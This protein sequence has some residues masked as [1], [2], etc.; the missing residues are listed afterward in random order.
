MESGDR[1]SSCQI[2]KLTFGTM[3]GS[4][5][6]A[7]VRRLP[8][9]SEAESA[10]PSGRQLQNDRG[11][12]EDVDE[13][14]IAPSVAPRRNVLFEIVEVAE[15][16]VIAKNALWFRILRE[17]FRRTTFDKRSASNPALTAGS[18]VQHDGGAE[19]NADELKVVPYAAS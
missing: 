13:P 11:A 12:Y 17:D 4:E 19:E 18:L 9:S 10:S 8:R 6:G 3:V 16:P 7:F 1:D 2:T 5:A 15:V 14:R